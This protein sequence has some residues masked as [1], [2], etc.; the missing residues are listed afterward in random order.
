MKAVLLHRNLALLYENIA[1]NSFFPD[2]C[3]V[4]IPAP[5]RGMLSEFPAHDPSE[6]QS[7]GFLSDFSCQVFLLL[8]SVLFSECPGFCKNV[9]YD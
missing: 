5:Q 3:G 1:D 8:S 6:M 2:S 7:E 4:L 9:K